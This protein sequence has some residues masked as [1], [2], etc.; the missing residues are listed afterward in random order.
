MSVVP[1]SFAATSLDRRIQMLRT[2]MG[3]LIATALEDPDV[4]EIMLNPDR[5]LWVDRLSSGRAPM[6]VELSEA[7]GER[8]IRLVAAHVGAEV[9]R[10][11]PL[12]TAELPETGERFE[13]ILP[14]AA[15]GPAF[16]LRKRAVGVIPLSRY[17]ADDM[18]TAAQ[19][20]LLV[21]AV[22]ERQN[23]LIAG[24]TSTGKTTLANALLAEIAATGDR[25]LVLEDTV[26]LQCAA[27]DHVP[28]R[29]RQGV[30]SMTEL[31][32][33][34]MRLRP[35]RVVVGEVRGAEALDLIKV[36]GTGHPGG[37]ATIHAGSAL[38]ALLRLEQLILEVAV[39]PPRAL[40]AE[41]VNVVI[42]IAGRGRKRR[43]ESI[44]RVVGF[45][46][47]GYHLAEALKAPFP[48]LTPPSD[49]SSPSLDPPGELS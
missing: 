10:G 49:L 29:T 26:E 28:L 17:I 32:R 33:S 12:L 47:A 45:D 43:I 42:H 3:P 36:W 34:S 38:G 44:A 39:N 40:I 16:A 6:G 19:A 15:P 1:S 46:G 21:R 13:G 41:A 9:H 4:V 18:M 31:V 23:I 24:G 30:V 20:G 5:S 48:E 22:R 8:I 7:D 14:P 11:Q 2:A 37:I 35:D 27:R 25:V